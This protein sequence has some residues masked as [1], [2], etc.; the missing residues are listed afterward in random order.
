M[1]RVFRAP[2]SDALWVSDFTYV[3]TWTGTIDVVFVIDADAWHIV[4]D[5][6]R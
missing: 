2:R 4:A 5:A 1:N 3:A 6:C